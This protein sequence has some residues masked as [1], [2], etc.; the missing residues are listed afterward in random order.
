MN[1]NAGLKQVAIVAVLFIA[2]TLRQ[3]S[4]SAPPVDPDH[5]FNTAQAFERLERILGDEKPHPVDSDD[6]DIVRDRLLAEINALGFTPVVRD[7]F[8][9]NENKDWN[10]M[11]CARV[12][13]V[14]F[15]VGAPGPDAVMIASH[16]D[17]VPAG[18][19]ASDDGAG[20]A[21]SLEIASILKSRELA[22]PVLVLITDGEEAGL[23]GAASFVDEDPLA[24]MIGAVVSMEARGVRGPVSMFETSTPNGRDIQI[25]L[26]SV[27][28]PISSS[29]AADIYKAMPN[30]TDVTEYLPLGV[31][32]GNYAF[33]EGAAFYHTPRDNLA[34][35]DKRS[36]FHMGASALVATKTFLAQTSA[37][38]ETQWIYT[39]IASR[40]IISAPQSWGVP[41]IV[42]GG[43]AALIIFFLKD[44]TA[45]IR[46]ASFP[47]VAIILGVGSAIGITALV[48]LIRPEAQF[49]SAHPW[50]LRGMQNAAALLGAVIAYQWLARPG[51]ENRL[52]MAGWIWFAIL[53]GAL[54]IFLPGAAIVFAPSLVIIAIAALLI[55]IGQKALAILTALAAALVLI[56]LAV[57]LTALTETALFPENAAPFTIFTV[58]SFVF[59]VPLLSQPSET[60]ITM[61]KGSL[62]GIS[63]V[64]IL[65]AVLSLAV[66]AYS[67]ASPRSL[68]VFH[69]AGEGLGDA[70]W[71]ISGDDRIPSAMTTV[72]PFIRGEAHGLKGERNVA[73]A[74]DFETKGLQ[75]TI[76]RNERVGEEQ[77]ITIE[78]TA[79]DSDFI[80]GAL[81]GEDF[82][83]TSMSLN[84]AVSDEKETSNFACYG[85]ECRS[86]TLSIA[87]EAG[88]TE[89]VLELDAFRFGLVGRQSAQLLAARPDWVLPIQ[90]GDA[91]VV[92]TSVDILD[93]AYLPT[94]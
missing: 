34:M 35:L 91:R 71:A 26:T 59:L 76:T 62:A 43:L 57:P 6:G 48:A 21:A 81:E 73:A 64:A 74:P 70:K 4:V 9:C 60:G 51:A 39:D 46:S 77:L 29:L 50:A 15:W 53:G 94:P 89:L 17:S 14:M 7:D 13:N 38:P 88:A 42:I 49:A 85:R 18:P 10:R 86:F 23:I 31:D 5:I 63:G 36:L 56:V 40:V 19:G 25:L 41:M 69:S 79:L 45:P 52:L 2:F 84:G 30:G 90:T 72:A 80:V 75:A 32:A 58:L 28:K 92:S 1:N 3:F 65:F 54:S 61:R 22:R 27:K 68:T 44:K 24:E 87:F 20:I 67:T 33:T 55:G 83:V 12:R 16:Y 47:L 78:I 66:P 8:Y 93:A 82:S 37:E 11:R